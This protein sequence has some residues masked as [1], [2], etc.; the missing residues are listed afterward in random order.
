MT[1]STRCA[2]FLRLKYSARP[3]RCPRHILPTLTQVVL[4][5]ELV[6]VPSLPAVSCAGPKLLKTGFHHRRHQ[7]HSAQDTHV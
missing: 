1:L 7:Q 2:F 6:L 3:S 5:K 4:V